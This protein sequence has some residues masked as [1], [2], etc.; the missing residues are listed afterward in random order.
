MNGEMKYV[1]SVADWT[2]ASEKAEWY[3]DHPVIDNYVPSKKIMLKGIKDDFDKEFNEFRDFLDGKILLDNGKPMY[4]ELYYTWSNRKLFYIQ[5]P[6]W[7]DEDILALNDCRGELTPVDHA[8]IR[9]TRKLIEKYNAI[10]IGNN[11]D[12]DYSE[13]V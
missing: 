8:W 1:P 5:H 11:N 12:Q 9:N 4:P 10:V 7:F 2:F 3:A 6:E 13:A